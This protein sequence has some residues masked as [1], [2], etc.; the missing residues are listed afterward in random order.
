MALLCIIDAFTNC[1]DLTAVTAA[2]ILFSE[3]IAVFGV[4]RRIFFQIEGRLFL[5]C[6]LPN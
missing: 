6:S 2:K 3:V 5:M 4:P 1:P